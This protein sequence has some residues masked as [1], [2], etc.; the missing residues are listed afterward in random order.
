MEGVS[1]TICIV[2]AFFHVMMYSQ[3]YNNVIIIKECKKKD[4]L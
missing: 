2:S 3:Y 4:S 1:S